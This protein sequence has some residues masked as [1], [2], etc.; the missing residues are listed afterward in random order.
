VSSDILSISLTHIKVNESSGVV[1]DIVSVF[2]DAH[3]RQC[4][5]QMESQVSPPTCD[6]LSDIAVGLYHSY[7]V[8]IRSA[9]QYKE[10]HRRDA[11]PE[12]RRDAR[13]PMKVGRKS[14]DVMLRVFTSRVT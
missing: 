6:V 5:E 9:L 1:Q 10:Y 12:G 13:M 11:S 4:A 7:A 14:C 8:L 3:Q 2:I